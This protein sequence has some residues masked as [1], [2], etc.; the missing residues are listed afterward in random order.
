M[1]Y[2]WRPRCWLFSYADD[3]RSFLVK[4]AQDDIAGGA[5]LKR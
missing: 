1:K 5:R 2:P 4:D 3:T